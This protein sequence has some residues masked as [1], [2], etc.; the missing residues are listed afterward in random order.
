MNKNIIDIV[1]NIMKK[2]LIIGINYIGTDALLLGCIDDAK[3][4]YEMLINDLSFNEND[5]VI[6]TDD[7]EDPNKKP[8]GQ[9]IMAYLEQMVH[10]SNTYDEFWLHYSGH[11]SQFN[12]ANNDEVDAKDEIIVPCDYATKGVIVDDY[13]RFF[14]NQLKCRSFIVMDC[15]NSGSNIDLPHHYLYDISGLQYINE[16]K[17]ESENKEIYKFSGS[18]D[19]QLSYSLYDIETRRYRGACSHSLIDILK[20]HNYNITLETL[21]REMNTWMN[22]NM[23]SQNPTLSSTDISCLDVNFSTVI[24]NSYTPIQSTEEK[25]QMEIDILRQTIQYYKSLHQNTIKT[26][27]IDINNLKDEN[28]LLDKQN[29]ELEYKYDVF[30]NLLRDMYIAKKNK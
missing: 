28:N 4:I 8:T 6:L 22:E 30:K 23:S 11:G 16:N 27:E 29:K 24:H 12:D 20:K 18:E 21:L 14:I 3:S 26:V 25:L 15:C 9:N 19:P 1:Y 7:N 2:A 10:E 17:Y 5:I 13:L